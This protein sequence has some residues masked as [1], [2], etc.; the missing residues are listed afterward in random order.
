[1]DINIEINLTYVNLGLL[2]LLTILYGFA[3][4][5]FFVLFLYIKRNGA[6]DCVQSQLRNISLIKEP[7]T[8]SPRKRQFLKESVSLIF[9]SRHGHCDV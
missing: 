8:D 1:M 5:Y 9:S 4:R 2:L 6:D 3:A 7:R